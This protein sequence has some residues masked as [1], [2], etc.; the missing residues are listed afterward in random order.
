MLPICLS[1]ENLLDEYDYYLAK[2]NIRN[3]LWDKQRYDIG[4][5][6]FDYLSTYEN[7]LNCLAQ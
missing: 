3:S 5:K 7:L 2:E 6:S 4:L 1:K